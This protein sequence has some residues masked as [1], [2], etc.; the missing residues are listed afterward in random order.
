MPRIVMFCCRGSNV[1]S[2]SCATP[3]VAL[4]TQDSTPDLTTRVTSP[5]C[6]GSSRASP[7]QSTEQTTYQ[8]R[9]TRKFAR[10]LLKCYSS[11]AID[12]DRQTESSS[13]TLDNP[14]A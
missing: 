11:L 7:L 12:A 5:V 2:S 10:P 13:F 8:E 6:F 14:A 3:S 1:P 4:S 9:P